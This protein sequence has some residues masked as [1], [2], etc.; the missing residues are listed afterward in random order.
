MAGAQAAGPRSEVGARQ[1]PLRETYAEDPRTALIVDRGRT[2]DRLPGDAVHTT[3]VP[4]EEYAAEQVQIAVGTHRGVGGLHDAPNP[5]ELLCAA[6][7]A[8]QDSTVRMVANL[9]AVELTA[10]AVDVEGDV[11]LRGTLAVDLA[12]PVGFQ[13]F[14]CRTRVGVAPDTPARTVELLLMAAERSC[15]VLD[16]L[17]RGIAATSEF[18]VERVSAPSRSARRTP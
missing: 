2:V 3:A 14:R 10:L 12:V 8:C 1:A 7:A 4:G 9:L 6:L 11:D 13:A 17:R 16:T 18:D 15:V 5:G